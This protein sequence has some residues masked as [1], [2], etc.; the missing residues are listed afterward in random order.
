MIEDIKVEVCVCTECVMQGAMGL[1]ES[2]ESLKKLKGQLGF[3]GTIQ[4]EMK[5]CLGNKKHGERSLLASIN[6]EIIENADSET[7]M[8]KVI[9]MMKK[10]VK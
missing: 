2:V 3:D 8:E 4:V 1:V 10:D 9:S 5:K 7:V 6:G